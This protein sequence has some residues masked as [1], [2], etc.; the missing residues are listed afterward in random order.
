[1]K[2][3]SL[4][5]VLFLSFISIKAQ[6][7]G[8][9][10]FRFLDIPMT[11]RAAGVGGT[12][13]SVWGDDIN[14]VHSNPAL[15]NK[16]MHK[17]IAGNYCNYVSNMNFGYLA[18]AR[19][20]E[21][22]GIFGASFNF[23]NYGKFKGYDELGN[24]TRTFKANDYSLNLNYSIHLPEDTSFNL[25]ICVK[26]IL[27]QYE[28]YTA[29][30][31]AIDLG[32]TYHT[33]KNFVISLVAKNVGKVWKEFTPTSPME[34]PSNVQLG[35]SKKLSK[36]P[37][38]LIFVYDNLLKWNMKYV[39]PIDTAGQSNPFDTNKE[40]EDSTKF[41]KF[42]KR[43]GSNTDNFF[44]HMSFGTELSLSKNFMVMLGY[45]YRRQREFT[46]PER[47]GANGLCFGFLVKVKKFQFTYSYNKMA[48]AGGSSILGLTYK[49]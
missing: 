1:M 45:N 19:N 30:A 18:H 22:A 40:P 7:G 27:S 11:S 17:Q 28:A 13:M 15:L 5:F 43:F 14:L 31:N 29:F 34:L 4:Y 3:V 44:R 39:S 26:T 25:G 9:T 8:N 47:R 6:V 12:N 20:F 33:K 37:I 23:F 24:E 16:Y 42:S 49:L 41:Q 36:A 2:K 46:L 10:N 21:K 48:F 38:R 32:A 35:I